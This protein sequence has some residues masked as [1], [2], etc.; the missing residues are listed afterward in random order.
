MIAAGTVQRIEL[1]PTTEETLQ[2][3]EILDDVSTS[4]GSNTTFLYLSLLQVDKKIVVFRICI[5]STRR[6][7]EWMDISL[8]TS[9]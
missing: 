7:A 2:H 1:S 3:T 5:D 6:A 8:G 9:N 4:N